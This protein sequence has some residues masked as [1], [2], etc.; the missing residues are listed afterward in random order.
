MTSDLTS[1]L[2]V[3]KSLVERLAEAEALKDIVDVAR[4]RNAQLAVTGA[5][6]FTRAH[7]AQI[8]EGSPAA[9]DELMVSINRDARHR[10]VTVVECIDI[11]SRRFPDWSMACSGPSTYVDRHLSPFLREP[12]DSN[13]RVQKVQLVRL[14]EGPVSRG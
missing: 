6:I 14:I 5:L 13:T 4:S 11:E 1:L 8:L 9:V 2:Y 7:F 12:P 3:S 10:D